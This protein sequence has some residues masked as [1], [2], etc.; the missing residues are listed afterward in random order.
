MP[1]P[2]P[3]S[4]TRLLV[5]SRTGEDAALD[6]LLPLVYDEL[7]AIAGRQLR[8]QGRSP[9]LQATALVNEVWLRVADQK[10]ATL[11][12]RQH[13]L[14]LCARV[15]RRILVDHA[16]KRKAQKRGEGA[17]VTLET[18]MAETPSVGTEPLDVLALDEALEKLAALDERKARVV[19]LRCFSGLTMEQV[20]EVMQ[21]SKRTVEGDWYFARAWL[22][23]E[24]GGE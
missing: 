1:D 16:R 19:E 22:R 18:A 7:R 5:R 13:F 17:A 10:V 14:A 2:D 9:T 11:A 4:F 8:R 23:G 6:E 15:M 12:D 21:V 20:A 3:E 24:L